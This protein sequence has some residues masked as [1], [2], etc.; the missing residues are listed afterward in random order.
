MPRLASRPQGSGRQSKGPS[1][2]LTVKLKVPATILVRFAPKAASENTQSKSSTTSSS[3]TPAGPIASA[4]PAE[5]VSESNNT[6]APAATPNANSLP[7][8]EPKRR[9]IPGPKPGS[10]RG[11]A[12][13]P[14]GLPKPR[15][16]PGPKKKPRLED[17]TI[18]HGAGGPPGRGAGNTSAAYA[19]QK[20]GPKANQG[21]IN[22]GLRALDR[23]G[24]PCRKWEKKGFQLKSFTGVTWELPCWRA[25]PK[26][27]AT[28]DSTSKETSTLTGGDS[29]GKE[30]KASSDNSSAQAVMPSSP[31]TQVYTPA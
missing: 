7:P 20:L 16:K 15:G 9:G 18:D 17:G 30:N 6:P 1:N 28:G 10:K 13:G 11:P 8:P 3:A 5:Q 29:E 25:P 12:L 14:D 27:N 21:A 31:L 22:A 23:S 26:P 4:S 24:A 2:S 19:A